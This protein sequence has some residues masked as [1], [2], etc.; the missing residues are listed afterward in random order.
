AAFVMILAGTLYAAG[1][2]PLAT[3]P[4]PIEYGLLILRELVLGLAMAFCVH[5]AL[6]AV[7]TAG[8][9]VSHEIGLGYASV[10]DPSSGGSTSSLPLYYE[11]FFYLGLLLTDGHHVLF[12]ALYASF[13][14]APVGILKLDLAA[15]EV[16]LALV[17]RMLAAGITFAAPVLVLLF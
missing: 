7:R 5:G 10:V 1:G 3:Q 11:T 4:A 17:C 9:L 8:E 12:R 13:D 6:L 2:H 15:V 16:A 14:R